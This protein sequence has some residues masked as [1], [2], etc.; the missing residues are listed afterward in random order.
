L[1]KGA[2]GLLVLQTLG[3]AD[4]VHQKIAIYIIDALISMPLLR[5]QHSDIIEPAPQLM[6]IDNFAKYIE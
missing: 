1:E 5:R 6:I 2:F 4:L 3:F